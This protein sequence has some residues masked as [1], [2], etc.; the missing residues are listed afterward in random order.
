MKA[1]WGLRAFLDALDRAGDLRRVAAPVDPRLEMTEIASRLVRADGPAAL[2]ERPVGSR[3]PV[4]LNL[5]GSMR[6][7][8]LALGRPPEAVGEELAGLVDRLQPPSGGA[9]WRERRA[10]RRLLAARTR[11][12]SRA[13]VREIDAE[14]DLSALPVLTSWPGDAG[15]FLTFPLVLTADPETGRRNLGVYRMQVLGKDRTA[16]HWQIAKGGSCHH[17]ASERRERPMQVAVAIGAD[18]CLMLAAVTPLPE[19]VDELAFAGWLRGRP[20]RTTRGTGGAP[21]VPADAEFVLE[22]EVRPGE[23][24]QEGPFGDHYGHYSHPA[25]FPIFRIR[26]M[27][28]RAD[29]IYVASVVG[30]PPQED[31]AMGNAVQA[32]LLPLL[33]ILHPEVRDLWAYYQA[34]FHGLSVAAVRQRYAKEAVKAALGLLGTGQMALA[35]CLVLV[36][37]DVDARDFRGVLRAVGA[38]FDPAEDFLLLPRT[39][40]DTLDFS[41]MTPNLGSKMILDATAGDA[42]PAVAKPP[43]VDPLRLDSRIRR[44]RVVE[45]V[46]LVV[47]VP[48]HS[49]ARSVLESLVARGDLGGVR[50]VAAVSD[51][52]DLDD[53]ALVLW[54]IFTRFDPARDVVFERI[55]TRGAWTVCR[56][57]MGID[58]TFRPGYPDPVEMDPAVVRRVD[59]RWTEWFP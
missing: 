50:I 3:F 38:H 10:L 5:F 34:G 30:K 43:A 29:A 39:P 51:D 12:T 44:A 6:R 24:V 37:P 48:A 53:D 41:T 21:D 32:M 36:D 23:R 7:I 22:G 4:A 15:P 56:G 16:M 58:A 59:E 9:L 2:F 33:R 20:T 35:K 18:P 57:R 45:N 47:V 17:H 55:E 27:T 26:R 19:N 1:V 11:G 40:F 54:G 52:V 28:H 46:L 42:P 49:D 31:R 13:P 25:P 14:I 8:E